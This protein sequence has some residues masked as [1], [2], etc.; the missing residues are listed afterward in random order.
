MKASCDFDALVIGAGPGGYIAAI[1]AA[2]N[3]L[4][5]AVVERELLGGTCLNWGCIPTKT[6][7]ASAEV[8]H[9]CRTAGQFGILL[10]GEPRPDWPAMVRRKDKIAADLRK[11]VAALLKA[12]KVTVLRGTAALAGRGT[13]RFE[14]EEGDPTELAA[15]NVILASGSAAVRPGF[16]PDSPRILSS[17][18]ALDL[19]ELPES[20]LILGG[21]VIGCEFACLF[22]RLGAAVTV[23]E[24][25]PEILPGIDAEVVRVLRR[26]MRKLGIE[27]VT[28]ARVETVEDRGG[29]VRAV[30]AGREYCGDRLLVAVGRRPLTEGLGL[31]TAGIAVTETGHIPVNAHCRTRAP[32]IYAIGDLVAGPQLAHRAGAMGICAADNAAGREHEYSDA[33]TPACI[34]TV[35]EIAAVG[36]TEEQAAAE[37]RELRIGRFPFLALGRARAMAETGGFV[38][39]VADSATDQV[40]G[41]HIVGPH[42]TDLIGEAVAAIGLEATA[43]EL[44]RA[45]H[46][47][48]TLPEAV[49]EAAHDVHGRAIHIPPPSR[50]KS[51]PG[52]KV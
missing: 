31:E 29:D 18:E 44:A 33:R 45:V 40:L 17:R 43:E 12:N 47:H 7:I 14:P 28:G 2:Q 39:I 27:V 22:A 15:A 10:E 36:L 48:P 1:R 49:M 34:F 25:L 8:L 41:M 37:G 21:G 3:G 26:E 24:M 35:P 13:V 9:A 32:G 20:I 46:P 23:L 38:K 42:A 30:A 4:R 11:G 19:P 50:K 51:P 52:S 16:I 5:T 6:L